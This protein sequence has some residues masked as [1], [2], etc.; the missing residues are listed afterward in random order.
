MKQTFEFCIVMVGSEGSLV[1][2]LDYHHY[3]GGKQVPRTSVLADSFFCWLILAL[4]FDWN[5][6]F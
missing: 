3:M 1:L 6:N 5:E 2:E 4:A